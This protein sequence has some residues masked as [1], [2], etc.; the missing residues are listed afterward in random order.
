MSISLSGVNSDNIDTVWDSILPLIQSATDQ[1]GENPE[2]I[3]AALLAKKAQL[4]IAVSDE[5]IE[6]VC[7]TE[8]LTIESRQVCNIWLVAGR[9]RENWLHYLDQIEAWAKVKG[10][11]A[12]RQSGRLGWQRVLKS[13]SYR[14]VRVV[15]EKEL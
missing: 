7:V 3:R 13:R 9:N 6:A 15:L 11:V 14:V 10:C 8:L 1:S 5:G 2:K 4:V 12:M